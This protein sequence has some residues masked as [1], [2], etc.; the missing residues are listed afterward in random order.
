MV[1][2]GSYS[3]NFGIINNI[4]AYDSKYKH[5]CSITIQY[6]FRKGDR[7]TKDYKISG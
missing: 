4:R 1:E 6:S 5:I 2:H 7:G 3:D